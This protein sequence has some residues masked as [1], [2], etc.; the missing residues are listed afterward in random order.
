VSANELL[1]RKRVA[2]RHP[3]ARGLAHELLDQLELVYAH[4][5]VKR[6]LGAVA[7]SLHDEPGRHALVELERNKGLAP[8]FGRQ[9]QAR[10][11]HQTLHHLQKLVAAVALGH[12]Q[13][14]RRAVLVA[15]S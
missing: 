13:I 9:I 6:L 10:E 14:E 7:G 1:A 8:D 5:V 15:A 3:A 2:L 11:T 4:V 12:Q